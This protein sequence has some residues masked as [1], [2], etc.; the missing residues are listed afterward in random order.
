MLKI[1]LDFLKYK[2]LTL[3]NYLRVTFYMNSGQYAMQLMIPIE[4]FDY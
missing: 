4:I 1:C 2:Y 3:F